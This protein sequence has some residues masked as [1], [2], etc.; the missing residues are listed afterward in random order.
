MSLFFSHLWEDVARFW[1][2]AFHRAPMWPVNGY[3]RCPDCLRTYRVEWANQPV[4][5]RPVAV[6]Q[7]KLVAR[8]V[9]FGRAA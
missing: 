2:R 9:R 5:A 4:P 8:R 6:L 1:C 7:P 3:Y